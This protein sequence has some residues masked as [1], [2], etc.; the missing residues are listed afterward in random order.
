MNRFPTASIGRQLGIGFGL[1]FLL[2][3]VLGL[4]VFLW[5]SESAEAQRTFVERISPLTDQADD[6]ERALL[7]VAIEWRSHLLTPER[8]RYNQYRKASDDARQAMLALKRATRE[9][10]GETLIRQ[11]SKRV[12]AYLEHADTLV[13]HHLTTP[14]ESAE[15]NQL[16]EMRDRAIEGVQRFLDLQR[17]KQAAALATLQTARNRVSA[18]IVAAIVLGGLLAAAIAWVTA[19]SVRRPAKELVAIAGSLEAGDWTPAAALVRNLPAVTEAETRTQGEMRQ[20]A[21]AIGSAA[22]ALEQR[23]QSLQA[24]NEELQAQNEEIQAQAEELQAQSEELQAQHEEIQAQNE[25]LRQQAA[26]LGE[27]DQRKNRFLGVLAH[28]L[29]NPMAPISNSLALLKRSPPGS[30]QALRAQAMIERQA[31]HL[32]RLIDD[33]LDITRISQAKIRLQREELDLAEIVR[34]CIE[35]QQ[36]G[37]AEGERNLRF[38]APAHPVRMTADRTRLSQ[39]VGNLLSNAVK[40]T[41]RGGHISVA[42]RTDSGGWS[43]LSVTDDGIGIEPGLRPRL[44][45]PFTQGSAGLERSNGGLGLGLSLVRALVELHGGT[46]EARSEGPGRGAE[47]VVRLPLGA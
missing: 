2:L 20:L 19:Q 4:A 10:D 37:L 47:F 14:I 35:D 23:E 34:A 22:T 36:A 15:E 40:F 17:G 43:S 24:Q 5:H 8:A 25:Q 45:E 7:R 28:E 6:L 29:R 39:V 1:M 42:L 13:A 33:L 18:G 16:A 11:I 27:A 41:D 46:I 26:E 30:E 44:F 32:I 38:D 12:D 31:R 3:G 9:P 21:H